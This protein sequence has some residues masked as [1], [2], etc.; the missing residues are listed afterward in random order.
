MGTVLSKVG[1]E[2]TIVEHTSKQLERRGA[3][4]PLGAVFAQLSLTCACDQLL[5]HSCQ[6][7]WDHASWPLPN[8]STK[9]LH[10]EKQEAFES[11]L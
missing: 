5:H 10:R 2:T 8:L 6:V 7:L 1:T 4:G 9:T 11:E 3:G